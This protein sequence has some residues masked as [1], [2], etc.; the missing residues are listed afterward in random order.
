MS[1]RKYRY[2]F[3]APKSA[4]V[5]DILTLLAVTGAMYVAAGSPYFVRNLL[6]A[7]K[8]FKKY[9]KKKIH[10]TFY[11]L[12]K[13]GCIVIE[14]R[15]H[16]I[17]ISLT[18]GGKRKVG[19]MQVDS[20]EIKKPKRWDKKW[21]LVIFDIAQLKKIYREA[22]RGKLKELGFRPLQKSVW[23]HPF[24]CR[25]EIELLKAFFGLSEK[26]MRLMV[27]EDIGEA[28]DLKKFFQLHS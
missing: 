19:W 6:Q 1:I 14:K 11:A 27:V 20:L 13:Q 26:E 22:F 7:S 9:P 12:R 2:Y 21:R 25:P 5:K 28:G 17:Y 8:K 15:N 16:Q 3:K 23:A 24:D 18:E 4:I 10:D